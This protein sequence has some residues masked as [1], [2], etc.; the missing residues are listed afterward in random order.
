MELIAMMRG[1]G[2]STRARHKKTVIARDSQ[3]LKKPLL[4]DGKNAENQETVLTK[5]KRGHSVSR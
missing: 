1:R 4:I 3:C 5:K 2:N